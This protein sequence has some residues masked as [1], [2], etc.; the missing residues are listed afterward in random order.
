M[1]RRWPLAALGVLVGCAVLLA[2]C[3]S[4]E[5]PA[6]APEP[7]RPEWRAVDLPAPPG[8]PGRLVLR[9]AVACG[10]RWF[11][12]GA[13]ADASGGTRPAAWSSGDGI[14]WSALPVRGETFYGRQHVLYAAACR[15]G[16]VAALGAQVGGV[17]GNPR[18]GTW[19][20]GCCRCRVWWRWGGSWWRRPVTAAGGGCGVRW[21]AARRGG[22]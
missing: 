16:R 8:G 3:R 20:R 17:H 11:A 13:V 6:P 14:S 12:V 2:G 19:A 1:P 10:G 21:T 7:V 4:A 22:R 9:D 5:G 15:D 18:T